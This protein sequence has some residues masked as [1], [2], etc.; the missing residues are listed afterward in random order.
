MGGGNATGAGLVV[1]QAKQIRGTLATTT[2]RIAFVSASGCRAAGPWQRCCQLAGRFCASG[3]HDQCWFFRL[4]FHCRSCRFT[5]SG[6]CRG[7]KNERSQESPRQFKDKL[8][9]QEE[10]LKGLR[11]HL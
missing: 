3:L 6:S 7:R 5:S 2:A 11:K 8:R 4:G 10:E 9:Q 1:Q